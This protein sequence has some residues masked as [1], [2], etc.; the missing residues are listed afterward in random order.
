MVALAIVVADQGRN[1]HGISHADS[2]QHKV[3]I[4][5]N[6]NRR[7]TVLPDQA[8]HGNVKQKRGHAFGQ[9]AYH[10]RRAVG[11]RVREPPPVLP[12]PHE[13]EGRLGAPP[14]IAQA[15]DRRDAKPDPRC[16]GR[17]RY[18]PAEHDHKH[19]VEHNIGHAAGQG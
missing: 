1:A 5:H 6:G 7:N 19:Q 9:I 3:Q 8:H 12:G 2:D 11:R 13:P 4:E 16:D 17:A 10:L 18:P 14:E 15:K